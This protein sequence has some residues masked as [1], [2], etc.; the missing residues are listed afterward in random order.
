[1]LIDLD[2]YY[3][4]KEV[5]L[6][7]L[8][9]AHFSVEPKVCVDSTCGTGRLLDAASAVF[10]NVQCAGLDR[11]KNA[12]SLLRL[13]RPEWML[14]VGDL[15]SH[16]RRVRNLSKAIRQPVDLLV[17]NPPFSH[18][19]KKSVDIVYK[20]KQIKGSVAM[21]HLLKSFEVFNPVLGAVV[22][23]PE[24]LLYSD[25]DAVARSLLEEYYSFQKIADL[26][27]CTFSGARVNSSVVQIS[28]CKTRVVPDE[29]S[30]KA[31]IIQASVVRGGLPV[32][33][34]Q[35][36]V[37]GVPFLHSTDIRYVVNSGVVKDVSKTCSVA[38]GRVD[39]WLILIP[40]VGCA[41]KSIV[42]VVRLDQVAQL[43]DC[44][45]ALKFASKNLA[46]QAEARIHLDWDNFKS[47]YR[48][49]GARYLTISRLK[50]WLF[51]NSIISA[52]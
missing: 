46:L 4:P 51:M 5:A 49:T 25:T 45:V 33:L 47:L 14:E 37:D 35:S 36:S 40:R 50:H 27:N 7:A 23:V 12:I 1:M 52:E 38:K 6:N 26:Q 9:K 34:K 31:K 10:G 28:P 41:D 18:G 30:V 2:R 20:D 42:R 11:D 21:A 3:T 16:K 13:N 29:P 48:G 15:L 44:V 22:I 24:S 43:S 8:E 39:G 32:Y 19:K 17:L